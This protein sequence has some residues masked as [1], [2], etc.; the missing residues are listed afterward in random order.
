MRYSAV[1]CFH[2]WL[3]QKLPYWTCALLD[4]W[5]VWCLIHIWSF[6]PF[7]TLL[8]EFLTPPMMYSTCVLIDSW[9]TRIVYIIRFESYSTCIAYSTYVSL[10]RL[11]CCLTQ[12]WSFLCCYWT[13]TLL[14]LYTMLDLLDTQ[15]FDLL[16]F[17]LRYCLT[18][19]VPYSTE[20]IVGLLDRCC[21]PPLFLSTYALL[22]CFLTGLMPYSTVA[23]L[24]WSGFISECGSFAAS[25]AILV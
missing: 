11:V 18:Q 21:T 15:Q 6:S 16:D 8:D 3:A 1:I 14:D 25:T 12:L 5:L 7:T 24:D 22:N 10:T 23:L 20:T 17:A 9:C 4:W 19:E 13:C 2:L